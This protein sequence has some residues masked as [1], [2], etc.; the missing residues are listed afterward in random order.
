MSSSS[1]ESCSA[2]NDFEENPVGR[3]GIQPYQFEPCVETVPSDEAR[4][5]RSSSGEEEDMESEEE[6]RNPRL[7]NSDWQ[8]TKSCM[9]L[10]DARFFVIHRFPSSRQSKFTW[11]SRNASPLHNVHFSVCCSICSVI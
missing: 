2:S 4:S 5:A 6:E 3:Y 7:L 11:Q 9:I 8:V 10:A 1:P